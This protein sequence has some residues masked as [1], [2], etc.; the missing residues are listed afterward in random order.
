M[1]AEHTALLP[2]SSQPCPPPSPL[3]TREGQ[4][5]PQKPTVA[6]RSRAERGPAHTR[7]ATVLLPELTGSH[8][9]QPRTVCDSQLCLRATKRLQSGAGADSCAPKQLQE[10]TAWRC[11]SSAHHRHRR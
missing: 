10:S 9:M 11:C 7:G 5:G 3:L 1:A 6:A 2:A 4:K 8:G